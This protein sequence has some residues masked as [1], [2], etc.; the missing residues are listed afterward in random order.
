M[1]SKERLNLTRILYINER[2]KN[3]TT[4]HLDPN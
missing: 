1:E 4:V 2:V 3:L